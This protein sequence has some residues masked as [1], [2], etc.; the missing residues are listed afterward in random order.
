MNTDDI[1]KEIRQIYRPKNMIYSNYYIESLDFLTALFKDT[2]HHFLL[3]FDKL[4][5]K[6]GKVP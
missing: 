6:F 2:I 5:K 4:N 3:D 1:I